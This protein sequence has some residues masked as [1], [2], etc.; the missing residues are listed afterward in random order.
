MVHSPRVVHVLDTASRASGGICESVKGLT[1]AMIADGA[2]ISVV[3]GLDRW[4]HVDRN[5]WQPV[6]LTEVPV[7]GFQDGIRARSMIATLDRA[8]PE[9]VH[10]HGIWGV[11]TRA[12]AVWAKRTGCPVVL[13]PHGMIDPWA[14]QRSRTKKRIS[15]WVW[16]G[17]LLR[18][19][20]RFHALNDAEAAAI[21]A[22]GFGP[23]IGVI[24]NGVSLPRRVPE[25]GE[26]TGRRSLLF[27][28]RLHPKKGLAELIAAWAL[29]PVGVRDQWCLKIAGW[30]EVALLDTLRTQA[31]A[32]E[33]GGD[34][35]FMGPIFGA[36]KEAALTDA[37]AFILPSHSEGL[38]MTV[39]EAWSY[40]VPVFMTAACNIPSG[41]AAGAAFEIT[42]VPET[43]AAVLADVL[44]RTDALR[45]AGRSGRALVERDHSWEVIARE[46][47]AAYR[48]IVDAIAHGRRAAYL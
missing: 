14:W 31:A 47:I 30:D 3:A 2:P 4:S 33:I 5:T 46:T 29:L 9:I 32:L 37:D 21:A 48:S 42:T 45:E 35:V 1:R 44:P 39:L 6:P 19:V 38:P 16:E 11:G 43:I 12:T 20:A 17:H 10:L 26:H 15:A 27:I 13:S 36:E 34:V 23:D 18:H 28:G 41:F 24:S 7:D 8:A 22:H 25:R 40:G